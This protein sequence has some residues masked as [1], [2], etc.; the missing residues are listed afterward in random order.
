MRNTGFLIMQGVVLSE[1]EKVIMTF[2]ALI[3]PVS[4]AH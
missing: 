4:F 1:S 2:A 3:A